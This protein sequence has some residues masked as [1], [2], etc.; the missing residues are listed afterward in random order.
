MEVL[1]R[2]DWVLIFMVIYSGSD[3]IL[4]SKLVV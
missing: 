1:R 4:G 2:I 3:V